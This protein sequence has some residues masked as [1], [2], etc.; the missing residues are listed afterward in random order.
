MTPKEFDLGRG[1][2]LSAVETDRFKTGCLTVSL[3]TPADA[4]LSPKHTLL[5]G[6]LARGTAN[7]PTLRDLNRRMDLLYDLT[8]FT[9][10]YRMGDLQILGSGAYFVDPAYLPTHEDREKIEEE[11]VRMLM[12]SL[13][14]PLYDES[15]CFRADYT[16]REKKVQCDVIRDERNQPGAYAEQRCRELTFAGTPHAASF[17]GTLSEVS[18]MTREDLTACYKDLLPHASLRFFYVGS[19]EGARVADLISCVFCDASG[20]PMSDGTVAGA[21][22]PMLSLE[23]PR[24]VLRT[25]ETLPVSQGKLVMYFD[26]FTDLR[27]KDLFTAMVYDEILGGSPISKLFV[28]VREKKSLCYYCSST[29]DFYKGYFSV[30]SG[31]RCENREAAEAEILIQVEDLRRG[32]ISGA[33]FDAAVRYLLSIY[34][35]LYDSAS[36]IENYFLARGIYGVSCT[37]EECKAGIAAVTRED[38]VAFAQRVML[39]SVY[40][41]RGTRMGDPEDESYDGEAIE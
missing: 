22:P 6:V 37:P 4:V 1:M 38:V 23:P 31:I 32:N 18:Q 17:Y 35:G 8:L 7:D 39:R 24:E 36:A 11:N 16:E 29:F 14:A 15:G 40:F 25:E 26:A 13:Y 3:A 10:N 30:A 20:R 34:T 19:S 12:E 33:E 21:K 28:N 5:L 27:S 41:L 9:R 2:T